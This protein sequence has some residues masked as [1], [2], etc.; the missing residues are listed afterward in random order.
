MRENELNDLGIFRIPLPI[1]FAKAGGPVNV[2]LIE[3]ERGLLLYDAGLGTESSLAA[4]ADG[5]ARTG[6]RFQDVNRIVL[7]HGHVDH[8]G[9]ATWILEHIGEKIPILI[10]S[11]DAEKVLESGMALPDM[12]KRNRRY[13]LRLGFPLKVFEEMVSAVNSEPHMGERL[14]EVAPLCP[15]DRFRCKHVTLEVHHMPGHTPGLCCFY[16]RAHRIFF[17]ADH[18]LERVS[19]NPVIDLDPGGEPSS[20]KPLV[21]YF[22]SIDRLNSLNIDLV[23]PGHASPFTGHRGVIRSL[24]AFYH[25]RQAKLLSALGREPRT[26]YEAMRALFPFSKAFE[27]V[28]T[29]SETLGNLQVLEE[30]GK[31]ERDAGGEPIRYRSL[32]EN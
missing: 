7:S 30:K 9:A 11:A 31:V 22:N 27:L 13:L 1:P 4:L 18:L 2:Y 8:Y 28:L 23:L 10:H 14:A 24:S 5:F 12:L 21:S 25:R 29:L 6:H 15:G 19:P 20:F 17:S 16:D 32:S 3:E 26:V